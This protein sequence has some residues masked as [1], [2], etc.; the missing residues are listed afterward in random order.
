MQL[1]RLQSIDEL[2]SAATDYNELWRRSEVALPAA[3]AESLAEWLE[4]F[5]PESKLELLVVSDSGR[6]AAALPLV[7]QRLRGLLPAACLPVS[8]WWTSGELLLDAEADQPAVLEL[9]TAGLSQLPQPLIW[10]DAVRFA[11]PRW[12]AF[13]R[14]VERAG[15][16][17][18]V[19]QQALIGQVEIDHDWEDYQARWSKGH[20]RQMTV[21]R[22][23]AEAAG[24]VQLKFYDRVSPNEVERLVRAGF[25]VEHRSWKGEA[26]GSVLSQPGMLEYYVE[27]ARR[28]A[29]AGCLTLAFLEHG[30]EP[31]AF[32]YG[33]SAKGTYYSYKVGYDEQFAEFTPGQLLRFKLLERFH[34]DPTR[35]LVDFAGPLSR[36]TASWSTRTELVGRI[37]IGAPTL[38]G[39]L[40]AGIYRTWRAQRQTYF[41][42]RLEEAACEPG[43]RPRSP[44]AGD[45]LRSMPA[46]KL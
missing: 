24:G 11:A 6:F 14:A 12:Q 20:R 30:G 39:R 35:T 40:L 32:E 23:K 43:V 7:S 37:V 46:T 22:R 42:D 36:A 21:A 17:Y 33:M 38:A 8:P 1:V 5:A 26:R 15:L 44:E 45:G 16:P 2:L 31:I 27:Q 3:R 4:M 9:L 29:A 41:L 19:Q 10:L 13:L 28:L 25:E 34:S 18:S